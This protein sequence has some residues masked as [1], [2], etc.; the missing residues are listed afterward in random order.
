MQILIPTAAECELTKVPNSDKEEGIT[1]KVNDKV[2][3][4]CNGDTEA[5]VVLCNPAGPAKATWSRIQKCKKGETLQLFGLVSRL[6][7]TGSH[8][9]CAEALLIEG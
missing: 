3:V 2:E 4:K 9:T 8:T 1:G 5:A 6:E 7:H